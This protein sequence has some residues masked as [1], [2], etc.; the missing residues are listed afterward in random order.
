MKFSQLFENVPN[1]KVEVK[2]ALK[3]TLR[4]NIRIPGLLQKYNTFVEHKKL[5]PTIPFGSSDKKFVGTLS[6]YSHAHLTR[7]LSI[8]YSISGK[9]PTVLTLYG[10][11]SHDDIGTGQPTNPKRMKQMDKKLGNM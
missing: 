1:V 10:I 8:I 4:D 2:P 7:D 6:A 9:N 5:M 11:W 3:D